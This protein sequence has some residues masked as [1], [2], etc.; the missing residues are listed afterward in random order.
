ML[1]LFSCYGYSANSQ[2]ITTHPRLLL[3]PAI[4]SQLQSRAANNTTAWGEV[5]SLTTVA[6]AQSSSILAADPTGTG[7]QYIFPLMLSYYATGNIAHRNKAIEIFTIYYSNHT[8]DSRI[9]TITGPGRHNEIAE[10]SIAYDWCY[11]FLSSTDRIG[12]RN[13]IIAWTDY[14]ISNTS[15]PGNMAINNYYE[16]DFA[17]MGNFSALVSAAY[18]IHSEDNT[19]GNQYLDK[20]NTVQPRIMTFVATR[21]HNGDANEGWAT[22]GAHSIHSLMRAWG[23]M[24][25]ASLPQ[26]NKFQETLYE[27]QALKFLVHATTP[28]NNNIIQDGELSSLQLYDFHR[29]I[30]D[31]ISFYSDDQE[32][33]RVAKFFSAQHIPFTQFKNNVRKCWSF[34]FFNEEEQPLDYKTL[35]SYSA[36]R[37]FTTES[38]TGQFLERSSWNADAQWINFKAGGHYG[39]RASDG[40]GHFSMYEN[41]WLIIDSNMTT[42]PQSGIT[43]QDISRNVVQFT[44]NNVN[45]QTLFPILNFANA[46]HSRYIHNE[47]TSDYSYLKIDNTPIYSQRPN[48]TVHIAGRSFLYIPNEKIMFVY[49]E[50]ANSSEPYLPNFALHFPDSNFTTDENNKLITYSNTETTVYDHI[51]IPEQVSIAE[52]KAR[53]KGGVRVAATYRGWRGIATNAFL[54]C[55]YTSPNSIGARD[56]TILDYNNYVTMGGV[57][58]A[59]FRNNTRNNLIV[60]YGHSFQY[61]KDSIHYYFPSITPTNHIITQLKPNTIYYAKIEFDDVN[62]TTSVKLSSTETTST[63][64]LS[65]S[66]GSLEFTTQMFMSKSVSYDI[67]SILDERFISDFSSLHINEQGYSSVFYEKLKE[68]KQKAKYDF[69]SNTVWLTKDSKPVLSVLTVNNS[70]IWLTDK[71]DE[72]YQHILDVENATGEVF[73]VDEKGERVSII[74]KIDYSDKT[75]NYVEPNGDLIKVLTIESDLANRNNIGNL[76][77]DQ[78]IAMLIASK[79]IITP[80]SNEIPDLRKV[81][82]DD[83]YL[84]EKKNNTISLVPNPTD[85]EAMLSLKGEFIDSPI[86]VRVFDALGTLV[87]SDTYTDINNGGLVL[88]VKDLSVGNYSVHVQCNNSRSSVQLQ[89]IR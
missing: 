73:S 83:S 52:G 33:R 53:G 72:P 30:T 42:L 2:V 78:Y 86:Q 20:I 5:Q 16:G 12:I 59:F 64:Y 7:R 70:Q 61:Q 46:E 8:S 41:G 54:Q 77:P 58:G 25:T 45:N 48:N 4:I 74:Y 32:T 47:L 76:R 71:N 85:D 75:L 81:N 13:R 11:P 24:K 14:L 87:L 35:A 60:L 40:Q 88:N 6:M 66:S 36:K 49:D 29:H 28:T 17:L 65:S 62:F 69:E 56:M 23:I 21:L 22:I 31:I 82:Y 38:G 79:C 43:T 50:A 9:S 39:E 57:F 26:I 55:I 44:P 63:S 80:Y 3:S 19:K 27:Q 89:I 51:L 37:V 18:A 1:L 84:I 68:L 67:T 15:H 10:L 34:L